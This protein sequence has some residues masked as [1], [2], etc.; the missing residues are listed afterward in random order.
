MISEDGKIWSSRLQRELKQTASRGYLV[1]RLHGKATFGVHTLV[2]RAFKGEPRAGQESR[3]IDGNGLNN[4]VDNLEWGTKY[5]NAQD[6][7]DHGTAVSGNVKLSVED[8]RAIRVSHTT[9]AFT[10]KLYNVSEATV[11]RIRGGKT[12]RSL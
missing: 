4:N 7:V 8:V 12:W 1:V 2:L 10:A 3:H 11:S 5:E 6:R 9:G